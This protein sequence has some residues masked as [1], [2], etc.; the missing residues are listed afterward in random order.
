MYVTFRLFVVR[1]AKGDTPNTSTLW[2]RASGNKMLDTF[3]TK[4]FTILFSKYVKLTAPNQGNNASGIQTIGSG[5]Q[6]GT[7]TISRATRIVKFYIPGNKFTKNRIIQYENGSTQI[8]FFDYHFMI[9]AYSN[10]STV[11][12]GLVNKVGRLNDCFIKMFYKDA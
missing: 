5:F 1:S 4:R 2:N 10:F 3:N 8:K 6:T 7:N 12:S 9:Y 11:D